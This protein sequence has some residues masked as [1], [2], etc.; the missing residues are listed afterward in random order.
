L[1]AIQIKTVI[2]S[3]DDVMSKGYLLGIDIGTYESKGVLT[4]MEGKV[5]SVQVCPHTIIIPRQG[6]LNTTRKKCGGVISA[7]LPI[8]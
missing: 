7:H 8:N 2:F 6:W 3:G 4:D 5:V 1:N